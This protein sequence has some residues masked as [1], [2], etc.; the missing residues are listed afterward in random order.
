MDI[1]LL[2]TTC[3][4]TS[5]SFVDSIFIKHRTKL[6]TTFRTE[7]SRFVSLVSL[8]VICLL[9]A[10]QSRNHGGDIIIIGGGGGGHGGGGH[11][12]HHHGGHGGGHQISKFD[13]AELQ[14]G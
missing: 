2:I 12:H 3:L 13:Q 8:S 6:F 7:M 11:H 9:A 5:L 14:T 10:V 4:S 1:K